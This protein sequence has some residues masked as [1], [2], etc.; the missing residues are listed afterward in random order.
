MAVKKNQGHKYI[1]V[2]KKGEAEGN[3]EMRELLGGK[4]ANLAEMCNLGFPVPSGL[5]ISTEACV[6]YMELDGNA[7]KSA[8]VKKLAK[9]AFKTLKSI[10]D[11]KELPL[12]SVRSGAR[13]SMAGMMDTI[14]NVGIS[15]KEF[16][17]LFKS[18]GARTTLDSYRRFLQMYGG[19]VTLIKGE[20]FE[21]I[22]TKVKEQVGAETDSDLT[23]DHLMAVVKKFEEL[24]EIGA[25]TLPKTY[26]EQLAG[27][28]QAVFES[29]NNE[30]AKVYRKHHDI[31]ETWGTAVNIQFMVFGNAHGYSGSGV[32]FTRDTTTGLKEPQGEFL[33]NAQGE[34]V[35]AGVRTPSPINL[36]KC[37]TLH[38]LL[39]LAESLEEHYNDVQDI[40][41]TF[42]DGELYLLQTRD[43]KRT[44]V[45]ELKIASDFVDEGRW[46]LCDLINKVN[47][48]SFDAINK[49]KLTIPEGTQTLAKGLGTGGVATGLVVFN[50]GEALAAEKIGQDFI[51]WAK[52]TTPDDLDIMLKAKAIVTETGGHTCH[53]AVVARSLNLP[54][55]VG[56]GTIATGSGYLTVDADNGVVYAGILEATT[57]AEPEHVRSLITYIAG[58]TG[59]K[60]SGEVEDGT[61]YVLA[62]KPVELSAGIDRLVIDVTEFEQELG[63]CDTELLTLTGMGADKYRDEVFKGGL[64]S[65]PFEWINE[66]SKAE[67]LPKT[68]I[69][70]SKDCDSLSKLVHLILTSLG[71][72]MATKIDTPQGLMEAKAGTVDEKAIIAKMGGELF[73]YLKA[74]MVQDGLYPQEV[75]RVSTRQEILSELQQGE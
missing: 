54:C 55:V 66:L 31:P 20:L 22:L 7:E 58:A 53:A 59:H 24:Y 37:E 12:V 33:L 36:M 38:R 11:K 32:M 35:V 6:H 73:T 23:E 43:A 61:Q 57:L 25:Q 15:T 41:F 1:Y 2:F 8:F 72:S 51:L 68:M 26:E 62:S 63:N 44:S 50:K 34:D 71:F 27:S 29:W 67:G 75:K 48:Y 3:A 40:E 5:T 69:A 47:P 16:P 30:R 9:Q 42:Q 49:V 28:I 45:A 19:T 70:T 60:V 74:N 17:R 18:L 39:E 4:G 46:D 10:N 21:D 52:D 56:T 64:D 14:L 65:S 13:I